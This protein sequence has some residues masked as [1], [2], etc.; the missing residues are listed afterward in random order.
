MNDSKIACFTAGCQGKTTKN[1][2]GETTCLLPVF[3]GIIFCHVFLTVCIIFAYIN[4]INDKTVP[5]AKSKPASAG[6]FKTS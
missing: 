4:D 3:C 1:G 2:Q 6:H 5:R